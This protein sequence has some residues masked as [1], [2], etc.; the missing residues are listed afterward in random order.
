MAAQIDMIGIVVSDMERSLDFY[1]MLGLQIPEGK[2]KE[3]HVEITTPNGYRIAW[4]TEEFIKSIYPDWVQPHGERI[5]LAFKCDSPFEVDA[6]FHRVIHAGCAGFH[7]PWDA[8]WGQRYAMVM[9]PDL[10][11]IEFFA[12]L[13]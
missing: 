13:A 2:E 5:A 4:D 1:R 6:L 9:D 11:R 10:N 12:P 8:F 7:E 3:D